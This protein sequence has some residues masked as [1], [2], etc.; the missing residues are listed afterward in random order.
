MYPFYPSVSIPLFNCNIE[1]ADPFERSMTLLSHH[2][3]TEHQF[4][5][6]HR[7]TDGKK[8]GTG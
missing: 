4:Y 5:R 7:K 8:V 6:W 2:I 1:T 3:H